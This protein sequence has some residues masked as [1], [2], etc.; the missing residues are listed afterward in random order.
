M[1]IYK[2][3]P[4]YIGR[5]KLVK[6][7]KYISDADGISIL[8]SLMEK[9]GEIEIESSD[10]SVITGGGVDPVLE[11]G[12]N[13]SYV[14]GSNAIFYEAVPFTMLRA[15]EDTPQIVVKSDDVLAAWPDLDGCNVEFIENIGLITSILANADLSEL[16]FVGTSI[17]IENLTYVAVGIYRECYI[18]S[19]PAPTAISMKCNLKN[20]LAGSHTIIVQ[21][22]QGALENSNI[23]TNLNINPEITSITPLTLN[24][25]GYETLT[26]TGNYFPISLE[27]S[28]KLPDFSIT[29]TSGK[30]CNPKSVSKTQI[31]CKTPRGLTTG[32]SITLS[33]NT[34][35]TEFGTALTVTTTTSITNLSPSVISPVVQQDLVLTFDTLP[36]A[37][38]VEKYEIT[39]V[40]ND[41]NLINMK[42]KSITVGS[43][44]VV[45][46]FP[47]SYISGDY[48]VYATVDGVVIG[49]DVKL[50][51]KVEVSGYEIITDAPGVKTEISTTGRDV[52]RIDGIGFSTILSDNLVYFGTSQEVVLTG[53]WIFNWLLVKLEL[54]WDNWMI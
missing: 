48:D 47:G 53:K 31:T 22:T 1:E 16:D 32:E 46:K 8:F 44:E 19:S 18:L 52:V 43:Q 3:A 11:I 10:Q 37:S 26:I 39:L 49:G 54:V 20:P 6:E 25:F 17:P 41:D 34:L 40:G 33:I 5:I 35:S 51:L 14:E 23:I 15:F 28:L 21:T 24:E 7:N 2:I 45:S 29:F 13:S 38:D 42:A 30:T 27:E 50:T 12:K 9:I 36:E 4:E